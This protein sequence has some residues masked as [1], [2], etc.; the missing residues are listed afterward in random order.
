MI[1]ERVTMQFE[2]LHYLLFLWLLPVLVFFYLYAALL[3][4][5]RIRNFCGDDLKERLTSSML[6]GRRRLKTVLIVLAVALLVTALARPQWGYRWEDAK[7]VGVDIIVAVDVSRS[8]LAEDIPPSRLERARR[9]LHDF[10]VMLDGDRIGLVAFAG[11]S[12][13]QCPLTLDYGAFSMFLE[14]VSPEMIPMPG[15]DMAA[16]IR[17][18]TRAFNRRERTSKALILITDGEQHEGDALQA[19]REAR[20]EGVRIFVIGIGTPDGTPVPAI[21][22]KGGFMQDRKGNLILS[23]L[24]EE[25]LQKI[26]LETGGAYVRSVTG[27]LDLDTIYHGSI[28]KD[29]EQKD[30]KSAR[31]KRWEERF[32]WFTALGL[33]CLVLEFFLRERRRRERAVF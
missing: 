28:K 1:P 26:A 9:K 30:L 2:N 24:D 14:H 16:A 12:F 20:R 5:R 8:M 3:R 32:Q 6:H 18:A 25:N 19:A 27:D 4:R 33:L 21:D 7:R 17:T 31:M 23:R 11:N 15:T 13:L 29:V 22:G 10:T